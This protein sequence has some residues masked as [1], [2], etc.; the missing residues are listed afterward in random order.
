M[1]HQPLVRTQRLYSRRLRRDQTSAEEVMWKVL[2]GRR[3]KELKFR[4]QHPMGPFVVDFFCPELNL[5]IELDGGGH[6]TDQ[7]VEQDRARTIWLER[8]GIRELRFWNSDVD[9]NLEGILEK[10]AV[11]TTGAPSPAAAPRPLPRG[12]A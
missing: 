11:E 10:L 7:S 4:R 6:A 2:R 3:F 12:E 8:K 1:A 9:Q 5:A